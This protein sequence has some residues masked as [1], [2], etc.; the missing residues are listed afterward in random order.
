MQSVLLSYLHFRALSHISLISLTTEAYKQLLDHDLTTVTLFLM[1][2]AHLFETW[3]VYNLFKLHSLELVLQVCGSRY[4]DEVV[5]G[6][7][8]FAGKGWRSLLSWHGLRFWVSITICEMQH[9]DS[10]TKGYYYSKPIIPNGIIIITPS[11]ALLYL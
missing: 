11:T 10:V 6:G 4:L 9:S 1:L 7:K 8:P 2:L 5:S 3:F